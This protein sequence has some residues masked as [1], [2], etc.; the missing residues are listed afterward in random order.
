[1]RAPGMTLMKMP[2]FVWTWLITAFLLVAVMPVLAAAITMLLTDR[3]FGT[4]FF[5][6]AGGGDPVMF[7]HIF[8]FFGHV[9][10]S[11]S[12]HYTK[13][14]DAPYV[15]QGDSERLVLGAGDRLYV[16]GMLPD[17]ESFNVVRKGPLYVDPE[18][19]EVLGREAPSTGLGQ[20]VAQEDDA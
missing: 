14:Y 8:W 15:V 2:L 1:M 17:S 16:R 4:H 3:H 11:Y 18:T 13:L 9:I 20:A 10:T 5:N 19:Q 12:I 7:Q 6:A